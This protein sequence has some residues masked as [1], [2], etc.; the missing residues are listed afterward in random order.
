MFLKEK[1][2]VTIKVITVAGGNKQRYFISKED[3]R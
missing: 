1:I 3:A 2:D